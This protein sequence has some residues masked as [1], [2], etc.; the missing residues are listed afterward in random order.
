MASITLLLFNTLKMRIIATNKTDMPICVYFRFRS[1]TF[2]SLCFTPKISTENEV[3]SEA[4]AESELAKVAAIIPITN[5]NVTSGP[6][7]CVANRGKI[8]SDETG[9][10]M[11][12]LEANINNMA[13]SVKNNK[14]SGTNAIPYQYMFFFASFRSEEHTSELQSRQYL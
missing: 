6:K 3:V 12:F 8:S 13:P 14:L 7:Y 9:K 4:N 1:A 10:A 11:L 2:G 5:K